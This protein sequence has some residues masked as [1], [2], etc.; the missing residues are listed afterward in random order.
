MP[1]NEY[2]IGRGKPPSATQ[3]KPGQ[4]GNPAGRPKG[5]KNF[6]TDFLE[7]LQSTIEISEG[8]EKKQITKQRALFKRL[9][10]AAIGG[11]V[12]A[13]DAV[14]K[15]CLFFTE[16]EEIAADNSLSTED[17]KLVGAFMENLRGN[18]VTYT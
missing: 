13:V 10:N 4:S 12:K 18:D 3:F 8:G 6:K 15:L 17:W 14:M 9:I 16:P 7:E 5:S 2:T 1:K 11:D